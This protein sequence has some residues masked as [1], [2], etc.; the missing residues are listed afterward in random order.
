MAVN[1]D[2][3]VARYLANGASLAAKQKYI[4]KVN[5]FQGNPMELAANRDDV[6]L[7]RVT[8]SVTSGRRRQ[9][10]M[11]TP[12]ALWKQNAVTKGAERLGTGMKA[13]E[14]KVRAFF[15]RFAP[16]FDRASQEVRAMP[17]GTREDAKAR[18]NRAID[19]LMDAAG[20]S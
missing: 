3:A 12:V 1:I 13:A 19:I 9:R 7:A 14:P 10:L 5:S 17:K 2:Q 8:E 6:F 11:A 20:R 15:Q 16:T 4:D 18:A